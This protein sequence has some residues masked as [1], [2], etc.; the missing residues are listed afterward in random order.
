[1]NIILGLTCHLAT[2][3]MHNGLINCREG[4]LGSMLSFLGSEYERNSKPR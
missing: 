1:M 2:E 3:V 4:N